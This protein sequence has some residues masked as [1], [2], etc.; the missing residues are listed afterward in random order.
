MDR[1]QSNRVPKKEKA[2]TRARRPKGECCPS[3]VNQPSPP[4][5]KDDAK[6]RVLI[7]RN[8]TRHN[9]AAVAR[10]W[11]PRVIKALLRVGGAS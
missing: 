4:V 7:G 11:D 10:H 6:N 5:N 8:G 9:A 3:R 1:V 2:S